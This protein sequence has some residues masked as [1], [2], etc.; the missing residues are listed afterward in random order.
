M[1][2]DKK[3]PAGTT[4]RVVGDLLVTKQGEQ[5]PSAML[6]AVGHCIGS[7]K[8][9]TQKVPILYR[10]RMEWD[11]VDKMYA[12]RL[13][14]RLVSPCQL[15]ELVASNETIGNS[16]FGT[17]EEKG[18]QHFSMRWLRL[19]SSERTSLFQEFRP[20]EVLGILKTTVPC[21]IFRGQ[22]GC[23]EAAKLFSCDFI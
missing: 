1:K 17:A 7:Q 13:E 14:A 4:F 22:S 3:N 10:E 16:S 8:S 21:A 19:S 23:E 5:A 11:E 20:E 9:C 12:S 18:G 6:V 15:E 2:Q